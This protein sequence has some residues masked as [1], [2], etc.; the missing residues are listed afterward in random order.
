MRLRLVTLLLIMAFFPGPGFSHSP[1]EAN[2]KR[3]GVSRSAPSKAVPSLKI[4]ARG[5]ASPEIM[6]DFLIKY[7][8]EA[9]QAMVNRLVKT[10]IIEANREG[11]N[12][13]VAFCQ[14]CLETGFLKFEGSVNKYQHNYCGLGCIDTFSG[15][16]WFGSME[17]GIRAHIQHL[18]AYASIEPVRSPVVD[19]RFG[20]VHRGSVMVVTDLTG[21]WAADPEYGKK[22]SSMIAR[23]YGL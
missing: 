22:I 3:S 13:E 23:L 10:Y 20:N 8:V 6:K 16:D 4:M 14:M 19:P 15:G 12:Y 2:H 7:N 21:K 17:E 5:K 11:V 18:K 9:D 1:H